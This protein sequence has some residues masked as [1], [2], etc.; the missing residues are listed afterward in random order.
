MYLF[1]SF[2]LG[3]WMVQDFK[4]IS[5][6][7]RLRYLYLV[8]CMLVQPLIFVYLFLTKKAR[9]AVDKHMFFNVWTVPMLLLCIVLW[10]YLADSY[11]VFP[12]LQNPYQKISVNQQA[13]SE[14]KEF[15]RKLGLSD[16]YYDEAAFREP[17]ALFLKDCLRESGNLKARGEVEEYEMKFSAGDFPGY[18]VSNWIFGNR[19]KIVDPGGAD[20]YTIVSCIDW[21]E[22]AVFQEADLCTIFPENCIQAFNPEHDTL[23]YFYLWVEDNSNFYGDKIS[24]RYWD[25]PESFHFY[26]KSPWKKYT[27]HACCVYYIRAEKM[28]EYITLNL[29]Q[30]KSGIFGK[31]ESILARKYIIH[32]LSGYPWEIGTRNR[33]YIKP[34]IV[35]SFSEGEPSSTGGELTVTNKSELSFETYGKY[36]LQVQMDGTWYEIEVGG[37]KSVFEKKD[38]SSGGSF[39]ET[40]DWSAEYG[41]LPAGKYRIVLEGSLY[42]DKHRFEGIG[43]EEL[44]YSGGEFEIK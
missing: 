4:R 41:E 7:S 11:A 13:I 10:K 40:V 9:A 36:R 43:H 42:N 23:N 12:I 39:M 5:Y 14:A 31:D 29:R 17:N 32:P 34:E 33:N 26:G 15:L 30:E 3:C 37:T 38:L 8:L 24:F 2:I 6:S 1:I 21:E 35:V 22:D 20:Y 18:Q 28:P 16:Y 25:I 19:D 44:V 27:Y